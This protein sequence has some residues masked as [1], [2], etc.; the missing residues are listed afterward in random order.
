MTVGSTNTV[1][2]NEDTAKHLLLD[3]GCLYKNYELAN[4]SLIGATSGG[5]EFDVTVKTRD[6]KVDGLKGVQKGLR[7]FTDVEITLKTALLEITKDTL[8]MSLMGDV[9]SVSNPD[10]HIITGRT[11]ILDSDYC[12]NI[13]LVAELSGS[14]KPIIIIIYNV[15]N[16][17]GLKFKTA[18]DAD[19]TLDTTLTAFGDPKKPKELPY[20]IRYP[21]VTGDIIPDLKLS[22]TPVIDNSK[23]L[24]TFD[25][26]LATSV[27]K[28]GFA[29]TI[30]GAA[31]VITAIA[32]GTNQLNTILLTL[33]TPPTSGQ[34][35]TVA[36]TLPDSAVQIKSLTGT[37][38]ATFAS[39]PVTNN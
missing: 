23:V 29:V 14:L 25:S 36:Y 9:D 7:K 5:S 34:I 4:E 3:S 30:A 18:D 31:D 15:L 35:V 12:E 39:M 17:D 32:R 24:L 27:F 28:D 16:A 37:V 20:E 8:Q 38:L 11:Y 26:D 6:V 13:A 19:N 22:S 1:S 10:Y 2:Y 33:T 21:K